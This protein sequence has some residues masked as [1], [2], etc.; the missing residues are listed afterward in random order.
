MQMQ[1]LC[2]LQSEFEKARTRHAESSEKR[3]RAEQDRLTENCSEY[4]KLVEEERQE[5]RVEREWSTKIARP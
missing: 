4:R 5:K 2:P 3:A 1:P